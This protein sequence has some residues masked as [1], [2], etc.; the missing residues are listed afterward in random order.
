MHQA[1][2]VLIIIKSFRIVIVSCI[3]RMVFA[4]FC[5]NK[6]SGSYRYIRILNVFSKRNNLSGICIATEVFCVKPVYWMISCTVM[7]RIIQ[8]IEMYSIFV[9]LC[10]HISN[11]GLFDIGKKAVYLLSAFR[12]FP[13]VSTSLT[14]KK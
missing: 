3:K 14:K 10:H 13:C 7:I 9:S 5:L 1:L 8:V 6:A 4:I 11:P 2:S 12:L